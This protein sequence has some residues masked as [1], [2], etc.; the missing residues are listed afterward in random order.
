MLPFL[1]FRVD[2]PTEHG[3]GER[4]RNWTRWYQ[5]LLE[6]ILPCSKNGG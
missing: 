5:G 2:R 3:T 4:P 1:D 6:K